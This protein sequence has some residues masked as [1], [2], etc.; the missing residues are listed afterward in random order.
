MLLPVAVDAANPLLKPD[1]VPRDVVVD[2]LRAELKV[3]PFAG[4]FG[5]DEHLGGLA[6]L[7]L[8]IDAAPRR[9]A[10]ADLH[11]TVDLGDGEAPL[12]ELAVGAAVLAVADEEVER[13]LMLGE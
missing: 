5:G 10:V 2:H 3:D 13:V 7:P 4:G 9:V 6:E 12:P 1:G 11:A 8:G